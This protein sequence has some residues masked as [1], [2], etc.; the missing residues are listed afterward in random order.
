MLL[1]DVYIIDQI[2]NFKHLRVI[3]GVIYPNKAS[4]IQE[5]SATQFEI[6]H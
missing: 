2:T 5:N 1:K 4:T 6:G 3:S